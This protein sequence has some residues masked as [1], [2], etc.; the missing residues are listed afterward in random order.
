MEDFFAA[1]GAVFVLLWMLLL[2]YGVGAM[3]WAGTDGKRF[4]GKY[5]LGIA[6][7]ANCING[8]LNG[9]DRDQLGEILFLILV[10][11]T[12]VAVT[13]FLAWM[14]AQC[15]KL[16]RNQ[17]GVF[18]VLAGASNSLLV[19]MP[20][21]L[22]LFGEECLPYAT[23]YYAGSTVLV[24][25]VGTVIVKSSG[26]KEEKTSLGTML[27]SIFSNPPVLAL[28]FSVFALIVDIRLPE[29]VMTTVGYLGASVTSLAMIYSG[30]I[31]HQVGL[32]NLKLQRGLP[33]AL[34][35]RLILSPVICY[36]ITGLYGIN[37]LPQEVF[38][39]D[40]AMPSVTQVTVMAG[41]YGADDH[42]AAIGSGTSLLLCFLTIPLLKVLV[43]F[44]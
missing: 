28:C 25:S 16:P 34:V 20:L 17:K 30:L 8:L 43:P 7:P 21:C 31:L 26:E 35:F 4:L 6:I 42:Y 12:T 32:K 44:L 27:K 3:G 11:F 24:Q 19:G 39:V 9:L 23:A 5:I 10:S 29:N 33:T 13:F 18:I 40:S 2:G 36:G 38:V 14:V 15:L 22:Q 1:T 41:V 37:G